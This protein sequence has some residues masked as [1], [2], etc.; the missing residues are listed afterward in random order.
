MLENHILINKSGFHLQSSV[1]IH[2]PSTTEY[3]KR[4]KQYMM[5]YMT[6]IGLIMVHLKATWEYFPSGIGPR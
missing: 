2:R 3:N 1:F 4:H 5:Q 6:I